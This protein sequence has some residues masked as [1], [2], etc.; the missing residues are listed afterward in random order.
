MLSA[1]L[2]VSVELGGTDDQRLLVVK[3]RCMSDSLALLVTDA[4]GRICFATSQL[5]GMLGYNAKVLTDGMNLAG[6]LP[7]PYSQLHSGFMKVSALRSSAV[8]ASHCSCGA[9]CNTEVDYQH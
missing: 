1:S 6:L 4:K 7:L 5:A 9:S 3:L 8:T 2:Q